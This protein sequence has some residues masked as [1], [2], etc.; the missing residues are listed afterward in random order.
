VTISTKSAILS[1]DSAP[2]RRSTVPYPDQ[3]L[4]DDEQVVKHLHPHWITLVLPTLGFLVT[5]AVAGFLAAIVP[6]GSLQTPLRIAIL[7]VAL[8]IVIWLSFIPFLR[9]RTTHYVLT[10]HRVL[11]RVGILHHRGRDIAVNRIND[12]SFEQTIW[13]RLIGAGTLMVESAGEAGQQVLKDIPHAPA[14]QQLINRLIEGD[15]DRRTRDAAHYEAQY[16]AEYEARGRQQH[17][18]RLDER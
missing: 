16:E 5:A 9:W 11:I 8:L 2:P 1:V 6:S 4:A 12:V 14:V 13:E 18:E 15:H 7:A 17:T 10:T 3:L